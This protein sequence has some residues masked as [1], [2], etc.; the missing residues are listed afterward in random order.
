MSA[1]WNQRLLEAVGPGMFSGIRFGDWLRLLS[2]NA[3]DV[4]VRRAPRAGFATLLSLLVSV[5]RRIE[6]LCY[7]R[8]VQA[9]EVRPP[10]FVLGHWRS[11][12]T[13]LH[14]LLALDP[15]F[16]YLNFFQSFHPH[17]FLLSERLGGRLGSL[18]LPR[19]RPQDDMEMQMDSPVEDEVALGVVTGLSPYLSWCFPH[20]AAHYDRYLTFRTASAEDV[21]RWG[22]AF[23]WLAQKL[24]FKYES[25]PLVL[26]SP[27]HT[28]RIRLLLDLFPGARFL[29]VHR[30]PYQVYRSTCHTNRR[31][32]AF[33]QMQEI[34]PGWIEERVVRQYREMHEAFFEDRPRI[35]AGRFH[36]IRFDQLEK[37][38]LGQLRRAYERLDLPDFAAVEETVRA[39]LASLAGYRKNS[40]QELPAPLRQRLRAEWGRCFEEW[41]Y[42]S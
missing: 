31:V 10:L 38:P 41:G 8:K 3:F 4:S 13:H 23:R 27:T 2:D 18:L 36:E 21:A 12:T 24:A 14:N 15:R 22:A 37:D 42:P 6:I 34:E 40:F 11:G 25:R 28:A 29:H 20:R 1:P 33:L 16:A 26:K 30:H 32:A 35:P 17:G 19:R 5:T 39:Y 7:A 9:A